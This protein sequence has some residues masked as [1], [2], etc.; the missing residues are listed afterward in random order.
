[1]FPH[2][3]AHLLSSRRSC[4]T[5]DRFAPAEATSN[6]Q[7]GAHTTADRSTSRSARRLFTSGLKAC[8]ALPNELQQ[9]GQYCPP[10]LCPAD[11]SR[12]S[13]RRHASQ[14]KAPWVIY[15]YSKRRF[16]ISWQAPLT[17][18]N[19]FSIFRNAI[20]ASDPREG[21]FVGKSPCPSKMLSIS[22]VVLSIE[23]SKLFAHCFNLF[24]S[25]CK[26]SLIIGIDTPL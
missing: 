24:M 16:L 14:A 22:G 8:A 9:R 7:D 17:S 19:A 15:A 26:L 1:M 2:K 21:Q 23:R 11:I 12:P 20:A 4:G 18:S 6:G 3:F 5:F 25:C 10:P 13:G